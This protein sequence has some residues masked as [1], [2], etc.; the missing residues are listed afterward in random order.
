MRLSAWLAVRCLDA[1]TFAILA[2]GV[3]TLLGLVT[4]AE[5]AWNTLRAVERESWPVVNGV[6]VRVEIRTDRMANGEPADSRVAT[7]AYTLNDRPVVAE[8]ALAVPRLPLTRKMRENALRSLRSGPCR[9]HYNPA[10]PSESWIM[11]D[12]PLWEQIVIGFAFTLMGLMVAVA[13]LF[14]RRGVGLMA[15]EPLGVDSLPKEPPGPRRWEVRSLGL[16]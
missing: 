12:A 13:G 1:W 3:A 8:Q 5:G 10:N 16:C 6:I 15:S 2:G 9:V 4:V 14:K 7:Y 11:A